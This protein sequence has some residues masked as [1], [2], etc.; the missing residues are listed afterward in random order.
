MTETTQHEHEPEFRRPSMSERKTAAATELVN[1]LAR[2]LGAQLLETHISWVL[3]AGERA[4]KI[5]KPVQLPFVDYTTLQ[6]R[7][8]FCAE[9]LR[10]NRRLAPTLYLGITRI[11]GSARAPEL[12]GA[13]PVR[14][15]AVCMRR[16]A[17]G[18]LFCER[19]EAG[20]LRAQDVD[21][22]ASV[23]ADF[24][25]HA[26]RAAATSGFAGAG[27]RRASAL[28]ALE[29]VRSLASEAA[30]GALR[31]WLEN[32]AAVLAPLW[33]VRAVDGHVR[34]C[35]GDLHLG[36]V[37]AFEG[38][39][40]AFDCIEFSPALRWID[41][42]D[43]VAFVVMDFAAYGRR[44]FAL[45]FLNAW[46]DH[47]GDHEALP[48]LRFAIVYRA[49]VRAQV[50][51]L[52]GASRAAAARRYLETALAWAAPG[53]PRLFITHGLPGSGKTLG[54]QR[55]LEAQGAIRLRSDVE[56]KRLFGLGPTEDS[57]ARGLQIYGAKDTARTYARLFA[58][59]R[60]ALQAGYAVILDAAFLRRAERG[61]ALALARALKLPFSILECTAPLQ[62]LRAR[63]LARKG[64]ASEA[65]VA[66]LAR[67]HTT[68]EPLAGEELAYVREMPG[69]A[70]P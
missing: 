46:L 8:H 26:P 63:I 6:A 65:D 7:R 32:E 4:Y 34:E 28:A 16:F 35:H 12:D 56:R 64:D 31:T 21:E 25:I 23:L 44:D 59:A 55:L 9:E 15:V 48:A 66:L 53:Q 58:L 17:P 33:A 43:D 30:L 49:L 47:T 2:S 27:E 19:L 60:I 13:G 11:T 40:I 70:L 45:R 20:T 51:S 69:A 39:T 18:A 37:V 67:L 50:E 1:R 62:L 41:T 29:G 22:L 54:S 10:L 52:R 36:N 61:A 24:H 68:A 42:I 14:E 57:H 38:E 3:L 5:K